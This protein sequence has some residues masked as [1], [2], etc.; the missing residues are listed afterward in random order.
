MA[1]DHSRLRAGIGYPL[2]HLFLTLALALG[3]PTM[4]AA[5][6]AK[7]RPGDGADAGSVREPDGI[8]WLVGRI[9]RQHVQVCLGGQREKWVYPHFQ[10]GFVRLVPAGDLELAPLAGRAAV[11]RGRVDADR[12]FPHPGHQGHCPGRQARSDWVFSKRGVRLKRDLAAGVE[13]PPSFTATAAEPF[14]GLSAERRGEMIRVRF[15]N[16]LPLALS[17]LT[18]VMHYEGCYGKPMSPSRRRA[19][20]ALARGETASARFPARWRHDTTRG[21]L[22]KANRGLHRAHSVQLVSQDPA[23]LFDLDLPLNELL[24]RAPR[25]PARSKGKGE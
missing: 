14:A 19:L 1:G 18:L 4:V 8:R 17:D 7:A 16:R 23:V 10:A 11:L 20:G 22:P 24:D 2:A 21:G 5:D 12:R 9:S 13:R 15:R 25:C 6:D 3:L